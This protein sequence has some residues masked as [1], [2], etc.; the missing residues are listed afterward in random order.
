MRGKSL[1]SR[2]KSIIILTTL[3]VGGT[4]LAACN[5]GKNN[6]KYSP[7]AISKI[8]KQNSTE[9][10]V[11]KEYE[12]LTFSEDFRVEFPDITSFSSLSKSRFK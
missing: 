5:S 10:V 7:T 8:G 3:L 1:K 9:A 4:G 12:N 6:E 11:S 2:I